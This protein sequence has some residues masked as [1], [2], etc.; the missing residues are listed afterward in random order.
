MLTSLIALLGLGALV[1]GATHYVRSRLSRRLEHRRELHRRLA[2]TV[3]G[4]GGLGLLVPDLIAGLVVTTSGGSA[5]TTIGWV[6]YRF[7]ALGAIGVAALVMWLASD[8]VTTKVRR[9]RDKVIALAPVGTGR[10]VR[11]MRRGL[12]PFP[13]EWNALLEHDQALT[14]R[15]LRYQRDADAAADRPVLADLQHPLTQ[16]A[17]TAMFRCD[18]LRTMAPP[19]RAHD[20]LA[21]DY[22]KAVAAFDRALAA[23]EEYADTHRLSN[24]TPAEHRAVADA[25]RT[26]SFLQHN[27]TTPQERSEAYSRISEQLSRATED[28]PA[29]QGTHGRAATEPIAGSHP[30][31]SVEER[32]RVQDD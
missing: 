5:L 6:L 13:Q 15:L 21:T 9:G 26:L 27:A 14:R 23:A 2:L 29:T 25:T 8:P 4:L 19:E 24:V 28:S 17:V 3:T 22:G 32:A 20:V 18:D 11:R 30:W 16:A 10:E 1:W 12:G 7:L 31:L